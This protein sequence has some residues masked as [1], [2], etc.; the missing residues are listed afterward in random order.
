SATAQAVSR[1]LVNVSGLDARGEVIF[2]YNGSPSLPLRDKAGNY[3]GQMTFDEGLS[4]IYFVDEFGQTKKVFELTAQG[5]S[6]Y[7]FRT[8]QFKTE[9]GKRTMVETWAQDP[10]RPRIYEEQP[11]K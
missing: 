7:E 8:L 2:S 9:A 3:A 5:A 6:D 11:D 4:K 10:D 1:A